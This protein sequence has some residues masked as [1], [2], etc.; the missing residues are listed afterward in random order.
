MPSTLHVKSLPL[1]LLLEPLFVLGA[2]MD[3]MESP[4]AS[5]DGW[6]PPLHWGRAQNAEW[7][8][9]SRQLHCC[10]LHCAG[11]QRRIK[12]PFFNMMA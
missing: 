11:L 10:N 8:Y 5:G 12:G 9:L 6:C 1:P 7:Q 4:G 3:R 2:L